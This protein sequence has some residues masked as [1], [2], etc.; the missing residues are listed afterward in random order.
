MD[1]IVETAT[2]VVRKLFGGLGLGGTDSVI[3]QHWIL[4]FGKTSAYL[5]VILFVKPMATLF[6]ILVHDVLEVYWDR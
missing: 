6:I 2:E 4:R 1:R 3:L 5:W